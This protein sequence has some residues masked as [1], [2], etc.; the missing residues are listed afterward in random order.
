MQ[1]TAQT[2]S[3]SQNPCLPKLLTKFKACSRFYAQFHI[4]F[5]SF[6]FLQILSFSLFFSYFTKS[7]I[8]ALALALFCFTLFSYLVLL[9]FFQT[10]KTQELALIRDDFFQECQKIL[11]KEENTFIRHINLAVLA[12]E[13]VALLSQEELALYS[14]SPAMAK[15][16]ARLHWKSF[17]ILKELLLLLSI[18]ELTLLIRQCPTDL[19]AHIAFAEVYTDFC[20]LYI[21]SDLPALKNLNEYFSPEWQQKFQFYSE[22]AI[23]ECKI[24]QEYG[25][26]TPWSYTRLAE[27]YH[28][29]ENTKEEIAQYEEI[30]SLNPHDSEALLNLGLLYFKE[31]QHGKGLK[32]YEQLQ[33][34]ESEKATLLIEQYGIRPF[35]FS[36]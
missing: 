21:P 23:I 8:S 18:E 30:T 33:Y 7:T 16:K 4:A 14:T 10:K 34:L 12:K 26:K 13:A 32:V 24:V 25:D 6:L 22:R 5:I 27:I 15:L 9:S 20:K 11:S 29:Q 17:H 35:S 31:G 1:T 36:F 3:S 2:F 19:Q 28:L